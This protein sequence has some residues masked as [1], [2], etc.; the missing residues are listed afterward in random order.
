MI[1]NTQS[2]IYQHCA[3]QLENEKLSTFFQKRSTFFLCLLMKTVSS[4]KIK[5]GFLNT[6]LK[7]SLFLCLPKKKKRKTI[8]SLMFYLYTSFNS[9]YDFAPSA[10]MSLYSLR[11]SR[12]L[13]ITEYSANRLDLSVE[14][15][16]LSNF[17]KVQDV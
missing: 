16:S 8:F 17:D 13:S 6:F 3:V 14:Q 4:P 1:I 5:L 15:G 10:N 11:Q 7:N 2:S 12:P 9:Y